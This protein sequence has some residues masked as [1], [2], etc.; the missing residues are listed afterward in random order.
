MEWVMK[1]EKNGWKI[2]LIAILLILLPGMVGRAMAQTQEQSVWQWVQSELDAAPVNER[3]TITLPGDAIAGPN[4]GPL[5]TKS[6]VEW[7]TLDLNGYS[8][9]R[10]LSGSAAVADGSVITANGNLSIIIHR[11]LKCIDF[12]LIIVK[13]RQIEAKILF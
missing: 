3:I 6:G 4:D 13:G 1:A 5:T 7:V 12:R 8:I 9:D 11:L 10:G 2:W